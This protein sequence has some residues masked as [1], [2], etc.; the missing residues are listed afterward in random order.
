MIGYFSTHFSHAFSIPEM[1]DQLHFKLEDIES[2][3]DHCRH[4][5]ASMALQDYRLSRLCDQ[6]WDNPSEDVGL[7][8]ARCGLTDVQAACAAFETCFGINLAD[9]HWQCF[10]SKASRSQTQATTNHRPVLLAPA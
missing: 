8:I 4:K 9:Y 5:T 1:A 2:A 10:I 7:Q 3:L 6:M